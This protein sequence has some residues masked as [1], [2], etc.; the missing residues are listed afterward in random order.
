MSLMD[1]LDANSASRV[2]EEGGGVDALVCKGCETMWHRACGKRRDGTCPKCRTDEKIE[3][4]EM[5]TVPRGQVVIKV[6]GE[7][8]GSGGEEDTTPSAGARRTSTS[9]R[10]VS[11]RSPTRCSSCTPF[12]AT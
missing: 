9:P 5:P 11:C 3:V 2:A 12:T 6:E 4:F 8:G 10:T 7:E 1:L